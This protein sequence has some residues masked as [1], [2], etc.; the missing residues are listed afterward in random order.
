MITCIL[1]LVAYILNLADRLMNM[2]GFNSANECPQFVVRSGEK[3]KISVKGR[4]HSTMRFA[5]FFRVATPV[6]RILDFLRKR[7]CLPADILFT[8][9]AEESHC[10]C[11][12]RQDAAFL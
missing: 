6:Y 5:N 11:T 4:E 1:P 12:T 10:L 2:V 8:K 9:R 3:K 7:R